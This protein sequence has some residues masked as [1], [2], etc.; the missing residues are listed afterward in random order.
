MES[1]ARLRCNSIAKSQVYAGVFSSTEFISIARAPLAS[2]QPG[3]V[4]GAL[5]DSLDGLRGGPP[6]VRI[7]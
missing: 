1:V 2:S 6:R 5:S 7:T 4:Y 3:L